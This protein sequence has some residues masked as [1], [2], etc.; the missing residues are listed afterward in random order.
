[1]ASFNATTNY[2]SSTNSDRTV[3][4]GIGLANPFPAG[5]VQP[6]GSSLGL[7]TELGNAISIPYQDRILPYSQQWQLS[8]QRELPWQLVAQ[9][10]YVGAHAVSLYENLNWNE[11]PDAL[12]R[13]TT[14]MPNP[15][16]AAGTQYTPLMPGIPKP[17]NSSLT[18]MLRE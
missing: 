12:R 5:L 2:A 14:T 15:P 11:Q 18:S 8:I 4:P 16:I 1:M 10:A 6:T 13:D 7:K 3:L 9:I 17:S